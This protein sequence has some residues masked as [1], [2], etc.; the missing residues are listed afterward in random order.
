MLPRGGGNKIGHNSWNITPTASTI[1]GIMSLGIIDERGT[2]F[3]CTKTPQLKY[4]TY[5]IENWR[6]HEPGYH[7]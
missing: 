6:Y 1:V 7:R 4:Y 2:G 3:Y 5:R